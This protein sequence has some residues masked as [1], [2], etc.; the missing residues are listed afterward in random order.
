MYASKPS[1]RIAK[2]GSEFCYL[3]LLDE[4]LTLKPVFPPKEE[5]PRPE[6]YLLTHD[7]GLTSA[8]MSLQSSEVFPTAVMNDDVSTVDY[9]WVSSSVQVVSMLLPPS[10]DVLLELGPM[11]NL[12]Y[13]SDHFSL[14][15]ELSY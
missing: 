11:P 8:A 12:K 14:V 15:F 13:P 4:G 3:Q 7:L 10:F 6:S 9:L 2:I 1:S 5:R